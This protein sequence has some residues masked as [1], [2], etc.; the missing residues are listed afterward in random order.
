MDEIPVSYCHELMLKFHFA[1]FHGLTYDPV[2][3]MNGHILWS[4]LLSYEAIFN[5]LGIY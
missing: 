4:H 1:A 5:P 2:L 3:Q